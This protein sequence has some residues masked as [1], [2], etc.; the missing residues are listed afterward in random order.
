MTTDD[1]KEKA[2][3]IGKK[4][5][6][7]AGHIAEQTREQAS[8][9]AGQVQE[10]VKRTLDEQ[11]GRG[12]E[13]LS[14]LAQAVRQTSHQ[15]RQQNKAGMARY[16]EQAAEQVDRVIH[17]VDSRD[18]GELLEEAETFA[19]RHPEGFLGGAFVLGLMAGRF[20]KSTKERRMNESLSRWED[21]NRL[22]SATP[23]PTTV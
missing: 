22:P 10:K 15:L 6:E 8:A 16:A 13:E 5:Q 4:T 1:M 12:V 21:Q 9:L 18:V 2:K 23:S 14:G 17:Y 19:R 11:K 7:K 3:E 20:M